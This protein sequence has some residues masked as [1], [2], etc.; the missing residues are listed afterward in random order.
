MHRRFQLDVSI[1]ANLQLLSDIKVVFGVPQRADVVHAEEAAE[2]VGSV[3]CAL[4]D[5]SGLDSSVVG[6]TNQNQRVVEAV[7]Y[8]L[9]D[10]LSSRSGGILN[11]FLHSKI[12]E[13]EEVGGRT[14]PQK[15]STPSCS[16]PKN[17]Q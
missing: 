16:G 15:R 8:N 11:H 10:V 12:K 5:A 4:P 14:S 1:V 13:D 6:K 3:V 7:L 17:S 9:A 2:R